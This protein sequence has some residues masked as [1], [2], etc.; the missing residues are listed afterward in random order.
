MLSGRTLG[1]LGALEGGALWNCRPR[2]FSVD[3]VPSESLKFQ[4][5]GTPYVSSDSLRRL[6]PDEVETSSRRENSSI[7]FVNGD[8]ERFAVSMG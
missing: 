5:L 1:R 6:R 3:T 4:S 8:S 2:G 7:E